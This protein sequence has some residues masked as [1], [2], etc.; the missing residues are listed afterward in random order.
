MAKTEIVFGESSGGGELSALTLTS[1]SGI[2]NTNKLTINCNVGDYIVIGMMRSAGGVNLMW[3]GS[4]AYQSA[5]FITPSVT[6]TTN[7]FL[8][9][10]KA[11]QASNELYLGST[12]ATL[13]GGYTV[14]TNQ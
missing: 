6:L 11:S 5:D 1:F 14:I 13:S 8:Y 4:I 10:M 2:S 7:V 9:L 3:N 12:G